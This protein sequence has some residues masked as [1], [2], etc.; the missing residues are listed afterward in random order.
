MA[1]GKRIGLRGLTYRGG[2][3]MLAWLLHRI[4]GIG[5]I[6][7]VGTHVVASFFMH[8]ATTGSNW[9]IFIN[10]IYENWIFQIFI[11]F[12]VIY[13][14]INGFRIIILDTWPQFLKF[15][16]EAIWLQ[17]MIFIPVYGLT[18]YIM[19]QRALTGG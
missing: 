8:V 10:T 3:P 13:H 6:L 4:S 16:R 18:I 14:T 15:Q 19:I 1:F 9:P 12:C 17:W 5:M 2:G 11:F 7:F